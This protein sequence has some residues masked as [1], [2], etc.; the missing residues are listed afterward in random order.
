ML[1]LE[2]EF[3]LD[4]KGI[5]PDKTHLLRPISKKKVSVNSCLMGDDMVTTSNKLKLNVKVEATSALEKIELYD[6]LKAFKDHI[7]L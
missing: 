2:Q 1:L 3:F 6:G 4:V 7:C 5:F